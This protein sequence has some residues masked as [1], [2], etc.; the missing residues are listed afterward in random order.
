MVT[1]LLNDHTTFYIKKY[2]GHIEIKLYKDENSYEEYHG[3]KS[4]CQGIKKV[5]VK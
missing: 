4:M 5:L 3:I 1:L 2:R